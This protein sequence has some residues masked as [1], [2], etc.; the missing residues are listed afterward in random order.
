MYMLEQQDEQDHPHP[1]FRQNKKIS[2]KHAEDSND[3]IIH[4]VAHLNCADHGGPTD[5]RII[6]EMV[7]WTDIPSDSYY[8]SP[9]HPLNDPYTPDDTERF[10]TFE[11]DDAGWNNVRLSM[12]TAL[13]LSHAM[14]R[15]L[16]LPPKQKV[17]HLPKTQFGFKDFF[18]LDAISAEHKGFNV[19][20]MDEFLDREA[21]QGK[22]VEYNDS[23]TKNNNQALYPP[24]WD[25][26][27]TE[28]L[29]DYLRK[30]G[31]TPEGWEPSDCALAIPSSTEPEAVEELKTTLKSIMDG[32][33][34]K[35]RPTL[36]EFNSNPTPVDA[37]LAERMREM[38]ADKQGD[39]E[40][41]LCIYDKPF[42]QA[43][44]IHLKY[45]D[46]TD[47]RFLTHFYAFIFFADWKQDLWSK[48]FV[49]DHLRYADD[50]MCAAARVIEALRE[51]SKKKAVGRWA[52][53]K[54]SIMRLVFK[55]KM[56]SQSGIFDALHVRRGDFGD[57]FPA[58]ALP[59]EELVCV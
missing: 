29:F 44:L 43:K 17:E 20:T 54:Q 21:K 2:N 53:M 6:D 24:T 59:A 48:R 32:S 58:V 36:E 23:G 38:V 39:D 31:N 26:D 18:H 51:H 25:E 8:L 46:E 30:I 1:F 52:A 22:M 27:D 50:I 7:F 3:K 14:G 28:P 45:D 49:R 56:K 33:Y 47:T 37:T 5:P 13:V 34:G 9:M 11:P 16:V 12:E 41:K 19:I 55:N 40:A 35:P 57:W 15:T 4:P 42:Q 10:L